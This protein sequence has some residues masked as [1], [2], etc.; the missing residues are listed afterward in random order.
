MKV[1]AVAVIAVAAQLLGAC[2]TSDPKAATAASQDSYSPSEPNAETSTLDDASGEGA[3]VPPVK[4]A[5]DKV[6]AKILCISFQGLQE[7]T[8]MRG[9][10]S[11][12]DLMAIGPFATQVRILGKFGTRFPVAEVNAAAAVTVASVQSTGNMDIEASRTLGKFCAK[13]PAK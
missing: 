4:P 10:L 7:M 1:V 12:A 11:A 5:Y 6:E 2:G 3:S 9:A 8:S 13:Y